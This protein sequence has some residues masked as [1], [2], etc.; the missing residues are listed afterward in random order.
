[1]TIRAKGHSCR[2]GEPGRYIFD[3]AVPFQANDF[4]NAESGK[5]GPRG[6]FERIEQAVGPEV[7]RDNS[8]EARP[9]T[10][11]SQPLQLGGGIEPGRRVWISVG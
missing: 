7:N 8:G 3:L 2:N 10:R 5:A 6:E 1:M 9:R 4:A 11:Y